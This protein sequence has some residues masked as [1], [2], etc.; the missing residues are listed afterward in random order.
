MF[1]GPSGI[2]WLAGPKTEVAMGRRIRYSQ[3]VSMTNFFSKE[4]QRSFPEVIF[5]G[6]ITVEQ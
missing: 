3:G 4:L 6:T 5:V 1:E 2:T